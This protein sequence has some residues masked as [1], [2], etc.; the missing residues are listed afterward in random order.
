MKI[1]KITLTQ[2]HVGRDVVVTK[3]VSNSLPLDFVT[4]ITAVDLDEDGVLVKDAEGYTV[5][6]S[7]FSL[8]DFSFAFKGKTPKLDVACV[9]EQRK[10][11][12]KKIKDTFNTLTTLEKDL[13]SAEK[14]YEDAVFEGE[15]LDLV[16]EESVSSNKIK[17]TYQ[18]EIIV[19]IEQ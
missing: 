11:V 1:D 2:E 5:W 9:E 13:K 7:E 6:V 3:S 12:A 8:K 18:P 14:L 4:K 15:S 16:I 17:V 10:I 19:L